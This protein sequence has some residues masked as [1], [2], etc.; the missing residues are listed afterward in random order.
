MAALTAEKV[1]DAALWIQVCE[2]R[3]LTLDFRPGKTRLQLPSRD[4]LA[5]YCDVTPPDIA[6]ILHGMEEMHLVAT[7]G[8]DIVWTTSRGNSLVADLLELR[9]SR[10]IRVMFGP[11]F[12]KSVISRLRQVPVQSGSQVPAPVADAGPAPQ[13]FLFGGSIVDR[14]VNVHTCTCCGV[15][16]P[17]NDN[18][19]KY[20]NRCR[21]FREISRRKTRAVAAGPEIKAG[22]N[23]RDAARHA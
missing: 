22:M 16:F 9:Y 3:L 10:Q 6:A 7:D 2:R 14:I 23:S 17:T 19:R 11:G 15:K 4:L 8:E 5:R 18:R 1:F 12:R 21:R 20:C 13:Q